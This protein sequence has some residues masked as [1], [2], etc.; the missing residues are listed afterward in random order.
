M[1][2]DLKLNIFGLWEEKVQKEE[3]D[4]AGKLGSMVE[5]V[6]GYIGDMTAYVAAGIALDK[7]IRKLKELRKAKGL[8]KAD[9]V[10]NAGD[11][12]LKMT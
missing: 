5:M 7:V 8:N 3:A 9:D 10:L 6:S 12:V 1:K 2:R 4:L 11:D